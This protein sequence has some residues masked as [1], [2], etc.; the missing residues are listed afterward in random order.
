MFSG[1]LL[2]IFLSSMSIGFK[3]TVDVSIFFLNLQKYHT[4][5]VAI[6]TTVRNIVPT[7]APIV[8]PPI[9]TTLFSSVVLAI[10]GS[11]RL[12]KVNKTTDKLAAYYKF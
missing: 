2:E 10:V 3:V 11:V 1:L 12:A 5:P 4:K 6:T 8:T 7:V 9:A